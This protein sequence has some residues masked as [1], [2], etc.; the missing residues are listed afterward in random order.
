M[1]LEEFGLS[2]RRQALSEA[3]F[4]Q[5]V[6]MDQQEAQAKWVSQ[7]VFTADMW[8][9]QTPTSFGSGSNVGVDFDVN[10]WDVITSPVNGKLEDI[11]RN[12]KTGNIYA[13]LRDTDG[14]K[15]IISHLDPSTVERF[16]SMIGK[17]ISVGTPIGIGGNSGN[18]KDI[19][20]NWLRKDGE[21]QWERAQDKLNQWFGSHTDNVVELAD[22][23]RLR[24]Q[25]ALDYLWKWYKEFELI[26]NSITN[27][28]TNASAE[29][30]N[31]RKAE[32]QSYLQSGNKNAVK[33][34]YQANFLD[35][36]EWSQKADH[37]A[38]LLM[39]EGLKGIQRLMDEYTAA[40]WDLGIFVGT[41]ERVANKVGRTTD[42]RLKTLQIAMLDQLDMLARDRTGAALTES[43]ERFYDRLMPSINKNS[44][45]NTAVING[46]L[47][48][49]E[50]TTV[51]GMRNIMK[52]KLP[53]EVFDYLFEDGEDME[54][55]LAPMT[56]ADYIQ[57]LS[58]DF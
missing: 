47:N 27:F 22:G 17:D 35:D 25:E 12:E 38:R 15:V 40:W 3:Q 2:Q 14:A 11:W 55:A 1:K 50:N 28:M 36:L 31:A 26:T 23:T 52:Q 30:Q 46:M 37:E 7:P 57:Q 58:L 8:A 39:M 32:L 29:K 16:S 56:T 34:A 9:T 13:I 48:T 33:T 41:R 24:W 21:V 10:V 43:E 53:Q 42:E 6:F 5:E 44:E 4:Q 45:F 51:D 18:V 20:G 49:L 54:L 19:E